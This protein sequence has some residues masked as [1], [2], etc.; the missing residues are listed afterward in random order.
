[1]RFDDKQALYEFLRGGA[2][3]GG[4]VALFILIMVAI[5]VTGKEEPPK[6]NFK[7]IDQ[8]KGCDVV[9]WHYSMLSEYKYFLHC[10]K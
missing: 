1:M 5:G 4:I 7:V 9:Q 6:T 8:Y 3:G 2:V 10:P